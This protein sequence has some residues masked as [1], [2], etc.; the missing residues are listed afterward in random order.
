MSTYF[1]TS[2]TPV[3][4]SLS[5]IDHGISTPLFEGPPIPPRLASKQNLSHSPTPP[6]LFG[7]LSASFSTRESSDLHCLSEIQCD[8]STLPLFE[9]L[10]I[11]RLAYNQ[12]LSPSPP[13][14]PPP[15]FSRVDASFS[16]T[17]KAAGPANF[18]YPTMSA[19]PSLPAYSGFGGFLQSVNE[20]LGLFG[21]SSSRLYEASHQ[22][23]TQLMQPAAKKA[24]QLKRQRLLGP[25]DALNFAQCK[26]A[27][28]DEVSML[29]W[30]KKIFLTFVSV[31]YHCL[32]FLSF[33]S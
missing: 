31:L 27:H 10:P 6:P 11:H 1:S 28:T 17:D 29:M 12:Y 20:P 21:S 15:F 16:R 8:A 2:E 9:D 32:I 22:E 5:V 30:S 26:L 3:L 13:P 7:R 19:P 25:L 18:G 4:Q 33:V 14:P 23:Q 24:Q